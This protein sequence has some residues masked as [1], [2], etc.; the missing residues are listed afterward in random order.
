ME[1]L[2]KV[3]QAVLEAS[4][5]ILAAALASWAIGKA[6]EIFKKLKDKNPELYEILKVVCREAVSAAEQVYGSGKGEQ[7]LKYAINVVEKYL[8]AKGISLDLDIILAY[9]EAAV[10]EMNDYGNP[11]NYKIEAMDDENDNDDESKLVVEPVGERTFVIPEEK[12]IKPEE[13]ERQS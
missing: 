6:L 12:I 1:L 5:P 3:L 4:L 9:I 11:S 2:S 13:K 7:K 10:K 8:E